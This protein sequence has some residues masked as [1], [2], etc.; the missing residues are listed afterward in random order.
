M[1]PERF[2][3]L[4]AVLDRRQPDFTVILDQV[5]KPHN[6]AAIARSCD[7]TG[8]PFVEAVAPSSSL[9]LPN[10]IAAGLRTYTRILRHQNIR[11][12]ITSARKRGMRLLAVSATP[13]A[14]H[15]REV[16]YTQPTAIVMG[17]EWFGLSLYAVEQADEVVHIPMQGMVDSLN[18]SVA[19]ALILFEM[20]EQRTADGQF[21]KRKLDEE[22]YNRLL[23]EWAY[24][25]VAAMYR[26]R[27]E[28][29]PL[30]NESG[31]ISIPAQRLA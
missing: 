6:L 11:D 22:T 31:E 21:A 16:D 15:Y 29:Y 26:E 4:K 23:F 13:D 12:A 28:R 14:T 30:L 10:G 7:A 5:E 3:K 1:T 9:H 25:R 24:P 20:V 8:V 17:E 27:S 2:E 19:T 18:V